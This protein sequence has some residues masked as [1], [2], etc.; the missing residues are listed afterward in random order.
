[1][2]EQGVINLCNK[3]GRKEWVLRCVKPYQHG[4]GVAKYL[5]R[6]IR[7]GAIKN[8][9]IL[10]ISEERVRFRYKSHQTKQTE[11]LNLKHDDFMQRLLDHIPIP[12]K[13]QYQFVGIYHGC[14]RAKLDKARAHLGQ[15]A[16]QKVEKIDWKDY[17][18]SKGKQQCCK[19]CGK[20][21]TRLMDLKEMEETERLEILAIH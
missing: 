20:P 15:V 5:A 21:L 19:E 14:C 1:M 18:A 2:T 8:S 17:V 13:Q 16:F 10:N 9:Q 6:Y 11:Y 3:L 12:K 7:G 4:G